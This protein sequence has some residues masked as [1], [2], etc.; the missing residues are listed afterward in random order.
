[1]W[2]R[3]FRR[4]RDLA[5]RDVLALGSVLLATVKDVIAGARARRARGRAILKN[6]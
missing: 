1:L 3:R 4:G 6:A 2:E 5:R